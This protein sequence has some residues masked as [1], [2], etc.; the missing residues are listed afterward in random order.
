MVKPI[1]HSRTDRY[2]SHFGI[3]D[4]N[5]TK[6][7]VMGDLK[8]FRNGGWSDVMNPSTV[9]LV[10]INIRGLDISVV[11]VEHQI[12]SGYLKEKY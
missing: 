6:V 3:F 12:G 9:D 8:V 2:E 4:I 7:K 11:S 5:G 1:G 10:E